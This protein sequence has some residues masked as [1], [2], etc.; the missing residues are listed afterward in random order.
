MKKNDFELKFIDVWF[1]EVVVVIGLWYF[2]L[3]DIK[4]E[5]NTVGIFQVFKYMG[6]IEK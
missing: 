3:G 4:Q 1:A 5:K 2:R 6:S